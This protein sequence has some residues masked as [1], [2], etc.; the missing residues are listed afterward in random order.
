M[1]NYT[2]I[3]TLGKDPEVVKLGEREGRKV[4]VVDKTYGKKAVDRWFTAI[5][6]GPDVA[7]MDRL[8]KGNQIAVT[9]TLVLE[10]YEPK[11]PRYKGEKIKDDVMAYAKLL[12]VVKSPSFFGNAE[13]GE[14][15]ADDSTDDSAP[16][17]TTGPSPLDGI[18]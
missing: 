3:V 6:S 11:K 2:A 14:K 10:E 1:N 9:G 16:S 12:Q 17:L 7:T 15:P 8:R 18:V 13:D 4:R 5:F